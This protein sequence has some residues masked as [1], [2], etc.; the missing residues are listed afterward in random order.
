MRIHDGKAFAGAICKAA[1]LMV[2][3]LALHGI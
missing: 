3:Y 1:I 2:L